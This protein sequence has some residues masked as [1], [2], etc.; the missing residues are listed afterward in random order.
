M[1]TDRTPVWRE[2]HNKEIPTHDPVQREMFWG[3]CTCPPS[4]LCPLYYH[5][6]NQE[7]KNHHAFSQTTRG[8]DD[9]KR[10]CLQD[11][12]S[13]LY[14]VLCRTIKPTPT[15]PHR[16]HTKNPGPVKTHIRNCN[17][18]I[19]EEHIDILASTSRGEGY[20]LTLEALFIQ[21]LEPKINT[22]DEW[23]SRTLTI[24]I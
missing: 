17:T 2:L 24:K 10:Y 4:L 22:K 6:D 11:N 16:E 14:S 8:E 1:P 20:L 21:E 13:S 3:I 12:M 23:R 5:N 9:Q 19:N 15:N 7:T 18:T